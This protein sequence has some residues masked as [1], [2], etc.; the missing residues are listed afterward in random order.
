MTLESIR[1]TP[2]FEWDEGSNTICV[3]WS[4]DGAA[5]WWTMRIGGPGPDFDPSGRKQGDWWK[6]VEHLIAS[7]RRNFYVD[8]AVEE[9]SA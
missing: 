5:G 7:R 2:P 9:A 4:V 6:S 3:L 1:L 8:Y